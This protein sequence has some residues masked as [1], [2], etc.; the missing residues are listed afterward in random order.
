MREQY[1]GKIPETQRGCDKRKVKSN[2]LL[3]KKSIFA[4][5]RMHI[6]LEVF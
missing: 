5:L 2:L 3:G 1:L 4:P 6:I